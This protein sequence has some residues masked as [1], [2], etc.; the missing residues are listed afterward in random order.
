MPD[1]LDDEAAVLIEPLACGVRAALRRP[2]APGER[3][4]VYGIGTLGLSVLQAARALCPD[5]DITAVVQFPF[6]AELAERMGANRA[7]RGGDLY[8]QVAE[9]TGARLHAGMLGTRILVGGFDLV[10]DCVG[11]PFSLENALRW[12]RA[13]GAVVLVGVTLSRMKLDLTPVWYREVTLYGTLA[14]GMETLP[15]SGEKITSFDLTVRWMLEGKIQT[16]GLLTHLFRLDDYRQAVQ[17]AVDKRKTQAVKVA[18][19]LREG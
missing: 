10:Y 14:H 16:D 19:D 15:G 3:V 9:L 17:T 4:L 13:G 8:A 1:A 11:A 7:L 12:T 18:F 6:Q 5:C 2:P